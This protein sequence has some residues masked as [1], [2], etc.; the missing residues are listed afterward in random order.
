MKVAVKLLGVLGD[1]A[2]KLAG[3]TIEITLP[4]TATATDLVNSLAERLGGP[5]GESTGP[6]AAVKRASATRLQLFVNGEYSPRHDRRL[7]P[8]GMKSANVQV[9]ITKPITGG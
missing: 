1:L 8:P 3:G 2:D 6:A 9:V 7:A 5:F 4:D